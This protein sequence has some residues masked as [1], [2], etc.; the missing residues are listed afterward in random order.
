MSSFDRKT[1]V[2]VATVVTG[3]LLV[4]AAGVASFAR[5]LIGDEIQ[6]RETELKQLQKQHELTKQADAERE[7]EQPS[8]AWHLNAGPEVVITMQAVQSIA[9]ETGI[10]IDGLKAMKSS[11]AGRQA[12]A[13]SGHGKPSTLCDFLAAIEQDGRLMILET[14]RLLPAGEDRI[15]FALGLATYYRSDKK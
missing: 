2:L 11:E 7:L 5:H 3:L 4:G 10:A 1:V 8:K 12:F 14:G 9:D 13:L 6:G 15:A